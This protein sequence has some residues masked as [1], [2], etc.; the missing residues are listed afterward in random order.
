M[1]YETY[2]SISEL[3]FREE[4]EKYEQAYFNNQSIIEDEEYD[5]LVDIYESRF[6][7]YRKIGAKPNS[8]NKIKLSFFMSSLKKAKDQKTIDLWSKKYGDVFTLTD[9]IDGISLGLTIQNDTYTLYTRGD[10]NYGTDVS[11]LLEFLRLPKTDGDIKIR[12]ELVMP[13]SV[14]DECK[15][16][17]DPRNVVSGL[18]NSRILSQDDKKLIK[19]LLFIT[20]RIVPFGKYPDELKHSEQLK[21]LSDM[22][23][24]IPKYDIITKHELNINTLKSILKKRIIKSIY[25]MDGLVIIDDN[26]HE[27]PTDSNPKHCIAFKNNT[28][29]IETRVNLVEWNISK[30]GLLKP[31]INI[32]PVF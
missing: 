24:T 8:H 4:L 7:C 28:E 5:K 32:E 13:I 2:Q 26:P 6:G 29:T 22:G 27:Y 25:K 30:N 20:Y 3:E 11:F 10:G 18:V 1:D 15:D 12:G 23:F 14:F 9:K 16:K 17:K 19:Q 21:I 31:R